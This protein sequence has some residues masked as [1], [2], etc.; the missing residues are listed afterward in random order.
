MAYKNIDNIKAI[1]NYFRVI[2]YPDN[3]IAGLLGNIQTETA[4]T[5]DPMQVQLSY[6]RKAE[7]GLSNSEDYVT[8]VDN[9]L[10]YDPQGRDFCN[11]RVGFGLT[12]LT[13]AGRKTGFYNYAKSKGASVGDLYTQL[14]WIVIEI[15]STGYANVR[16]AIKNN[17]SIEECARII[18]TEFERPAKKDDPAVQQNRINHALD[19]YEA[20][21]KVTN[22]PTVTKTVRIMLDAGHKNNENKSPVFP[23]Y[24]EATFNWKLQTYLKAELEKYGFV[25]GTTRSN[26]SVAMDVVPRGKAAAGFDLF[27]SLHSN[28]CGSEAVDRP[29][30][31]YLVPDGTPKADVSREVAVLLAKCVKT[32]MNTNDVEKTYYKVDTA[33]RNKDGKLNDNY[34]GVLHGANAV[35][36]PGIILEHSFHT[37]L[38]AAKW[39]YEDANILA[40]AVN[41]AKVLADYYGKSADPTPIEPSSKYPALPFRIKVTSK[42]TVKQK[43]SLLALKALTVDSGVYTIVELSGDYGKLKSGAGWVN[44]KDVT[45]L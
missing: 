23:S 1:I 4:S 8:K 26:Q 30:G 18:C 29:V 37:N 35:G 31:I 14:E 38:R 42:I 11:D 43:P 41:E 45:I 13:S 15:N 5:F 28:A 6:L 2:G 36:V 20:F 12:Q 22:A 24:N 34:Y 40:L 39:L 25:V 27:I 19:I 21:F 32:T 9:G 44:L 16:K 33:D 7:Y 17:W 10:W 3:F